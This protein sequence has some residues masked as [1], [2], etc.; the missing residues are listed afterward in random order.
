MLVKREK[1]EMIVSWGEIIFMIIISC[2]IEWALLG[3]FE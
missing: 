3:G 2:L 1:P